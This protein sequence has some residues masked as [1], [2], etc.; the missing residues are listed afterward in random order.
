MSFLRN[1]LHPVWYEVSNSGEF[2]RY[3]D[4]NKVPHFESPVELTRLSMAAKFLIRRCSNYVPSVHLSNGTF[5]LKGH[6]VTFLQDV[7][8]MCNELPLRKETL[9]VLIQYMGNK[10]TSAV[11]PKSLRV[12]R[13]YVVEALLW[14][15][16]HNP[17]YT[18]VSI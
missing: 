11:Y 18:D 13:R 2:I 4:G 16:K 9:V 7:S 17:F 6:S 8:A 3:K 15:K 1:N 10:D 14:L 5:A 12:N